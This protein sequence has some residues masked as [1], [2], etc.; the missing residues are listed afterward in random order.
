M[1]ELVEDTKPLRELFSPVA[2]NPPSCIVLPMTNATHFELKPHIIQ[3]LPQFHGI[4]RG[5]PYMHVKDFLEICATFRFQNFSEESVKLR[6]FS[7]SLKDK[8]KAWLNSLPSGSI[9]SW[10]T[11]V[12]KFLSKFFSM[13]KTT[14][15]RREITDFCQEEHEKFYESWE[16][17]KDLILKC[18]PHGFETWRLVQFFYNGLTQSSRNMLESMNRGGFLNLR[19]DA[20]YEFLENLSERSQQWDFTSHRD[21]PTPTPKRGG[22]YEVKE[23]SDMR[24]KL[25]NLTRK[26]EVLALSRTMESANQVHSEVCSLCGSHMHTMQTCPSIIGYS[27]NYIEQANALNNYGKS[28]ASPFSETYNQNWRNHPNF[29]WRQ[30]QPSTNIGGQPFHSQN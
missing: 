4:E 18:P 9:T 28:F 1:A 11:L 6:L 5:N 25:D 24:I 27:D 26:V 29:S 2:T 23:D 13:S 20:A 3:L 16:R 14:S 22:L 17:F 21:K 7:F 8:A 30:N 15:L 10:D 12:K 19:G